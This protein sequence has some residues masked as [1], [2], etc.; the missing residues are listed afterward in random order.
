MTD[1][2]QESLAAEF[3]ALRPQL[4][5]VAYSV[6]GTIG[7][8]D[9]VIQ[10][11]WLRLGR[12]RRS[13]IEDLRAWL[14]RVVA[15]LA[16]DVL[17]SARVRRQAYAGPWLP[18]PVV[19]ELDPLDRVT[20]DESVSMALLVVLESLSPAE[21]TAFVLH[22]VFSLGFDEIAG[23]VGRS[24]AAVRQL[25]SRARRHVEAGGARYVADPQEHRRVL[26]AFGAA[27]TEGGVHDLVAVLDT[28]CILRSDGGGRV[29]A[30]TKPLHGADRVARALIALRESSRRRGLPTVRVVEVNGAE[31]FVFVGPDGVTSVWSVTVRDGRVAALDIIR[32][33]D[34]LTRLTEA[35]R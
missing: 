33:P 24:E 6:L 18:E 4:R 8:A 32:N 29:T 20:L 10:E 13:E 35:G 2:P 25:A 9:D 19:E 26:E 34:K 1:H 30:M 5:R 12:V 15:R 31:G 7:E 21:R 22:D 23:I 17:G 16:T 14:I 11:A 27:L 3:E 28:T